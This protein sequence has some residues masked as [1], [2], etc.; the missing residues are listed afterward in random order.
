[1]P[2]GLR[3]GSTPVG[4]KICGLC[5]KG[6]TA[7]D[8]WISLR[9]NRSEVT[10]HILLSSADT[11]GHVSLHRGC[12]TKLQ[13]MKT[14]S[15]W[16]TQDATL[17]CTPQ[18]VQV[19]RQAEQAMEIHDSER[20]IDAKAVEACSIL[21]R[22]RNMIAF[23]GAGISTTAGIGDYRGLDG[24]WTE[25]NGKF[26]DEQQTSQES[27]N[28]EGLR[29]TLTHEALALL[30]LG[31]ARQR[32]L[33]RWN[34]A[35]YEPEAIPPTD[36]PL[37]ARRPAP[38][39]APA[40]A[41]GPAAADGPGPEPAEPA[42]DLLNPLAQGGLLKHVLSQNADGLHLM[43]GIPAGR[44]SELH[45]NV[46]L[47][48]CEDCDQELLSNQYV[49]DDDA[50]EFD[51]AEDD[52][53]EAQPYYKYCPL[54]KFNHRTGYRC[55]RC[56]GW[57]LNSIVNFGDP[58]RPAVI[59]HAQQV[60][61]QCD[62]ILALGTTMLVTPASD[63]VKHRL[64][65]RKRPP[66]P[67]IIC[68]RQRTP[69]DKQA[70]VRVFGDCDGFMGRIMRILCDGHLSPSLP[71]PC[72]ERW[73]AERATIRMPQYD[74]ARREPGDL[75][76]PHIPAPA[77]TPPPL[78]RA[79]SLQGLLERCADMASGGLAVAPL[80]PIVP[81][82]APS[83][84]AVD[85]FLAPVMTEVAPTPPP[86]GGTVPGAAA[87]ASPA[88][89][90]TSS[91]LWSPSLGLTPRPKRQ[92]A[93]RAEE[94]IA[95]RKQPRKSRQPKGAKPPADD[96]EKGAE[97]EQ[98]GKGDA[99]AKEQAEEQ[100]QQPAGAR[101]RGRPLV[102]LDDDHDDDADAEIKVEQQQQQQQQQQEETRP[103]KEAA[104]E[105]V[106]RPPESPATGREADVPAVTAAPAPPAPA[107][108]G[109]GRPRKAAEPEVKDAPEPVNAAADADA[110][111]DDADADADADAADGGAAGAGP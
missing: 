81:R 9:L 61:Q 58:L 24:A 14:G 37:P 59:K 73:L 23:T 70:A 63:L 54:C 27:I 6:I 102:L 40:P 76:I 21:L 77:G 11:L 3:S 78:G 95:Q 49:V 68:N 8:G 79:D 44:L 48:R 66:C 56:H 12:W 29:P 82:A 89:S 13:P 42:D 88:S 25:R 96:A 93:A 101:A 39:A 50:D 108:R 20:D 57:C 15:A 5:K 41:P 18:E 33:A 30:M 75:T 91:P 87:A 35:A 60:F 17:A 85:A 51:P 106:A 52:P 31:A 19:L 84:E 103:P 98:E 34:A 80:G 69:F 105:R 4:T 2:R 71:A 7:D 111:A 92:A 47:Q 109:R 110:D 94:L 100:E 10:K 43:S 65:S 72:Y 107:K 32:Q 26:N 74:A 67:L 99:Q 45:G 86:S 55:P 36:G 28:Y 1:M 16:T 62:G 97:G 104:A 22:S 46:F 38:P 83:G 90:P 64:G 53:S